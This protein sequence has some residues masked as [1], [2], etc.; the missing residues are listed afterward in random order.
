MHRMGGAE[1]GGDL[2]D[3]ATLSVGQLEGQALQELLDKSRRARRGRDDMGDPRGLGRDGTFLHDQDELEPEQL[4][5]G[6]AA[7]GALALLEGLRCVDAPECLGPSGEGELVEPRLRQDLGQ[8]PRTFQGFGDVRGDLGRADLRL[9]RLR[10][11]GHE[12]AGLVA[13]EV[14][15][16]VRHL[17]GAPV[18]LRSPEDGDLRTDGELPGP[19]RLVEEHEGEAG[20]GVVDEDLDHR[21]AALGAPRRGTAHGRGHQGLLVL[22]E[23]GD[24]GLMPPVDVAARVVHQKVEHRL[25]AHRLEAGGLARLDAA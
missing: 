19:P 17:T 2:V 5:E 15:D 23:R 10:V 12:P 18:D 22:G 16:R 14:D 8:V 11:D 6:K 25:D 13:D 1:V 9:A 21:L 4:V 20:R 3:G 24:L 7:A